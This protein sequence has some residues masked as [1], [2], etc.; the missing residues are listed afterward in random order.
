MKSFIII[1]QIRDRLD[2]KELTIDDLHTLCTQ[3]VLLKLSKLMDNWDT[4]GFYLTLTKPE[5]KAVRVDCESEEKR[6]IM[7][8]NKW[9]EKQGNDATYFGLIEAL[10]ECG[11]M[12]IVDEALDCL[13]KSKL[14]CLFHCADIIL[15]HTHSCGAGKAKS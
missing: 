5:I 4:I 14:N 12:D 10:E 1:G 13:K 7:M 2:K 11:R 8:L 15:T 6:R 9:S 3:D